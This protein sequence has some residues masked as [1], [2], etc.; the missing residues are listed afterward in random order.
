MSHVTA[1]IGVLETVQP[2]HWPWRCG[3]GDGGAATVCVHGKHG[4]HAASGVAPALV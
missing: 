4:S 2:D 1:Q 3:Y